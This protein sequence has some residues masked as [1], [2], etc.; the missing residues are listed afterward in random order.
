MT[1]NRTRD[2]TSTI[3]AWLGRLAAVSVPKTAVLVAVGRSLQQPYCHFPLP[4]HLRVD[5]RR[6]RQSSRSLWWVSSTPVDDE[7]SRRTV[8]AYRRTGTDNDCLP[9]VT[10]L[11]NGR[12]TGVFS[13]VD[14][15]EVR[16]IISFK[17]NTPCWYFNSYTQHC[18]SRHMQGLFSAQ[19]YCC[20]GH[21]MPTLF[22]TDCRGAVGHAWY[23]RALRNKQNIQFTFL[24]LLKMQNAEFSR[25]LWT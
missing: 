21:A 24:F 16:G 19:S 6:T 9:A 15:T 13:S 23:A 8:V 7:C 10:W 22:W 1:G 14:G 25:L 12:W 5:R 20:H 18:A 17:G 2:T 11:L 4:P 3:N